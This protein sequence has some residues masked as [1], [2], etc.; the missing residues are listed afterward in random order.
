MFKNYIKIAL[1]NLINHKQFSIINILG[2]AIGLA[3]FVLIM[4]WVQDELSYD[5]F[6]KNADNIYLVLQGTKDGPTGVTS[7]M[8]A[9]ALK[10]ELPEIDK[11]ICFMQLPESFKF[12]IQNGDKGFEE[13]VIL[14]ESGFFEFFSF[15]FKEG[16]PANA[17]SAPN[18]IVITEEIA[19]KYFGNENAIGKSL[20]VSGFGGK[21]L[22]KVSGILESIPS[23][24]NI[25][26]QIIL[27]ANWF[28][29]IG[30]NFDN[31]G[32]QSFSTYIQ[33]KDD[34]DLQSLSS[35]ITQCEIK[36]CPN[37]NTENL[38]YSLLPITKLH[39]YAGNIKFLSASGNIKYVQIFIAIAIIIL[40]IGCINYTNLSIALSLRR[41]KEIGIKKTVGANRK[42]LVFQFLEESIFLS[43]I[44]FGLA[45]LLV[46]LLL[47]QFNILTGKN[48]A[49]K[50]FDLQFLSLSLLI[51]IITGLISGSY[52]AIFLSSFS[53]VQILK[54]KLKIGHGNLFIRKG[55]VVLQFVTT[56]VIIVCTVIIFNQLHFIRYSDLGF[57]KENLLC[58]KITNE[59]RSK[60]E[61]LKNELL[62]NPEIINISRSEPISNEIT[63]T[64]SVSWR[65]KPINEEQ[66]FWVLHSDENLAATYKFKM[67]QGR[68]FSEQFPTDKTS[69]YVINESAAKSM[70][71][72][73]PLDNE[74]N[75]WGKNG[76]IIGVI[77]DFHFASF[78]IAIEPMIFKIPDDNLGMNRFRII[79]IRF[80]SNTPDKLVSF[81]EKTWHEQLAGSPFDYYFFDDSI[82]QQYF[83]EIRIGTIFKY[84]SFLSILIA[85]LGLFGLV[86][87]TAEQRT[88]EIGIRKVLG[89]SISN[90]SLILS[91]DYLILVILSNIIAWPVALYFMK[92]WLQNFA[93]RIDM[94]IGPFL[95]AGILA[96]VV[97]LLTVSWQ[98][99]RA[100]TANPVE[101]LRYE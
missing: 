13:N 95:L 99:I 9:P 62:K 36:N 66:R 47:P 65:G 15:K 59:A 18:S 4:L 42:V 90:V 81:I 12:V 50:F 19:E 39:L 41:T 72:T 44:A 80:K 34:I 37:Q 27:P 33:L 22:M 30:I 83:S 35:K 53:P 49:I 40:I 85:C 25:K 87:I 23:Q 86:S 38:S 5:Q 14:A 93:Y 16:N 75:L 91:K 100:A 32:D 45:I 68:Y 74:I 92:T 60:Y 101:S 82:N 54:G 11:S 76:N 8:L 48:L 29:N 97:A 67:S 31:W 10:Q 7:K 20:D 26:R 84:F 94:T 28:K 3:C 2:L 64:Q 61:V 78:H 73:S 57:D 77:K 58:V 98:A 17:L 69:A 70:G 51:I 71:L 63:S 52:P 89:A 55:L 21:T 56:I 46:E 96:L 6:H 1:R 43:V 79:T 24:S 88:K